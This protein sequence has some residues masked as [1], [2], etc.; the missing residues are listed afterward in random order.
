VSLPLALAIGHAD[1]RSSEDEEDSLDHREATGIS[2]TT[3]FLGLAILRGGA[4]IVLLEHV[5]LLEGVVDRR[6]VVWVGL[7]QHVVEYAGASRSRSRALSSRV[8]CE[9]L[10]PVHVA[11]LRAR[12]AARL[13][14]F[15]APLEFLM[16]LLGLAALRGR[17]IHALALL[18]VE[19]GPH[20]LIAESKAG[21]D[22][23]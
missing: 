2:V 11:S 10:V 17:V 22:V 23:E 20:H 21:G 7:L 4:S 18:A 1:S 15:L 12:L 6:L 13:I 3:I 19:D 14:A 8:N 9:G 16:G 5:A